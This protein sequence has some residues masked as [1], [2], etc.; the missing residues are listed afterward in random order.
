MRLE[1][2][3]YRMREVSVVEVVTMIIATQ[4]VDFGVWSRKWRSGWA[5]PETFFRVDA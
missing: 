2:P 5:E 3:H 4:G 1:N